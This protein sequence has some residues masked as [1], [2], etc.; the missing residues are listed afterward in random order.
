MVMWKC[1]LSVKMLIPNS[2]GIRNV[3]QKADLAAV[4]PMFPVFQAPRSSGV[5]RF[6][7]PRS[8]GLG[9]R[10]A[11]TAEGRGE[12]GTLRGRSG[13]RSAGTA[14]GQGRDK[15]RGRYGGQAGQGSSRAGAGRVGGQGRN[16]GRVRA[17]TAV[18]AGPAAGRVRCPVVPELIAAGL[19][20]LGPTGAGAAPGVAPGLCVP[21]EPGRRRPRCGARRACGTCAGRWRGESRD[22][23]A[24]Q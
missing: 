5:R 7:A 2:S 14:G 10:A 8:S 18:R 20:G 15:G 23:F 24:G 4:F 16:S 21:L 19:P 12:P 9:A 11:V 17:G 3:Y 13:G 6:P 1:Y 22:D